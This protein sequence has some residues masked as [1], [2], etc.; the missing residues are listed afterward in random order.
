[1]Q[2]WAH[3]DHLLHTPVFMYMNLQVLDGMHYCVC[4]FGRNSVVDNSSSYYKQVLSSAQWICK[5]KMTFDRGR[6]GLH[7]IAVCHVMINT[8]SVCIRSYRIFSGRS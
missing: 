7:D 1:M 8:L 2:F 4:S 6:L 3:R 5:F